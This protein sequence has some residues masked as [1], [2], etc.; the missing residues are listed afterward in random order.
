MD[1]LLT[2]EPSLNEI[3]QLEQAL[4]KL[5]VNY[6]LHHDLFS[7]PWWILLV[8][9]I[10]PWL[11]WWRLVD[12]D[13]IAVILFY[14]MFMSFLVSLMDEIGTVFNLWSYPTQLI[15]ILPRLYPVD[16]SF[17]PVVHMLI[18][19][20]FKR[21]KPFLIGNAIMGAVFA[22]IGEPLFVWMDIYELDHWEYYYSF[23][24]YIAKALFV[25]WLVETIM[26]QAG[27]RAGGKAT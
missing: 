8:T 25:K 3:K 27:K 24:I 22:F 14:G 1:P 26:A 20:Y 16:F 21:W 2:D 7:L 5:K 11:I 18:F 19:Q 4:T 9:Y 6:W 10:L 13:R 17:L 15:R 23:P 12:K